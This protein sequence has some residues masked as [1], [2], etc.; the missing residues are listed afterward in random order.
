MIRRLILVLLLSVSGTFLFAQQTKEELQRKQ[1]QLKREIDDLNRSL[2]DIQKSRKVSVANFNLVKRKIAA[3]EEL[4]QSINKDMRILDNNIYLSQVEINKLRRELDTLK[5]EY[6][7][8]LVFAYKNRSNYDYL[9]FIFSASTFNDA[10]KRITYLKS[11][12]Q[13]R[14]QQVA[15]IEK[16][17]T[18]IETKIANLNNSKNE[19]TLALQ[20]QSK[21]L[22]VLEDDKKEQNQVVVKLQSE[23]KNLASAIKKRENDRRQIQSAI[24]A[25][26]K[27]EQAEARKREQAAAA[28][29]KADEEEK[30]KRDAL[31]KRET[32]PKTNTP[33]SSSKPDE[34]ITGVA[35][36]KPK[37]TRTYTPL[38]STD[39]S[40]ALS[41]NF[42]TKK[43]T[44][45]WPVDAGVVSIP[46][47]QYRIP[48]TKLFGQSDGITISLPTGSSVKAVA[49]G[50]V[51][52]VFDLGG[53]QAV[54]VKHGK[55]FTTYSHLSSSNVSRGQTVRP[56]TVLG[57]A[58]ANEDGEGEVLFMVSN[59]R[60]QPL[61]PEGWLKRK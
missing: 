55:Y 10:I 43:G 36:T 58:A 44:I 22:Q 30:R 19:K 60:G 51:S 15:N 45:P 14:E 42:E 25:A 11:Y 9:N 49:D 13:Y 23:E 56:G 17:Q 7:K 29:R 39:E 32:T 4:I 8:S 47:G 20:D 52:S 31:A 24:T 28:K 54:L 35:S 41:I 27:R 5:Q 50:E 59:E 33:A 26:I 48:G 38:E 1:Q 34:A 61:N 18:L 16:T 2:R 6:A 46:F 21:Q 37:S 53:E 3:R 12:R 57:R 40:K